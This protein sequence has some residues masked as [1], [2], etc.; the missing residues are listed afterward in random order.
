MTKRIFRSVCIL[1]A[2]LAI[3]APFTF[4][5]SITTADAVGVI[6]DS[7]GAVVPGATVTLKSTESGET[8]TITANDQ[9]RYRFPLVK[10][11]EYVLTA[12]AKGLKSNITRITLL[13]GEEREVNLSM[14][15]Q[16]TNTIVEVTAE[17]ALVN[18]ENA[19]LESNFNQKQVV[20]VP[21]R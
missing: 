15:A 4:S 20:D 10:P 9:G 13:V 6:T 2:I 5:Q 8:R 1:A 12:A 16:G 19:N 18:A 11:G 7:T 17:A 3:A 14:N 21:S